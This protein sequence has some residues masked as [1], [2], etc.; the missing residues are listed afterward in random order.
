MLSGIEG[1]K[2]YSDT[3]SGLVTFNY[4]NRPSN[5]IADALD[6]E[7]IYVRSG[8]HCAPL[9][10]KYLGTLQQGAVRASLDFNTPLPGLKT[11][12][13]HRW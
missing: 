10:H 6:R 2:I 4:K 8:I 5:D 7:N 3:K 12:N 11:L 9:A 13:S 1:I